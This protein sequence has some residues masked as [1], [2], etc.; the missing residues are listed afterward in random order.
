MRLSFRAPIALHGVPTR[1]HTAIYIA[2]RLIRAA[3]I[4][5]FVFLGYVVPLGA[6]FHDA[7]PLV[8]FVV[9]ALDLP[10]ATAALLLPQA[11]RPFTIWYRHETGWAAASLLFDLQLWRF[12]RVGVPVYAVVL[13]IPV[14][15]RSLLRRVA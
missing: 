2:Q 3:L 1:F 15:C 14:F 6:V 13:S 8:A 10:I 11:Q 12:I 5:S 7:A 9:K 4:S